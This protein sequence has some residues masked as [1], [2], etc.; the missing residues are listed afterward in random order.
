MN[1]VRRSSHNG[2]EVLQ[3]TNYQGTK[4]IINTPG[5]L[6]I[7]QNFMR[8]HLECCF[9]ILFIITFTRNTD[10]SF[11]V[12]IVLKKNKI[13]DKLSKRKTDLKACYCLKFDNTISVVTKL[14]ALG[15]Y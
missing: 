2:S 5:E 7:T 12:L 10:Y 13:K 4:V 6:I 14:P 8:V 3:L 11:T 15:S 1:S 9:V